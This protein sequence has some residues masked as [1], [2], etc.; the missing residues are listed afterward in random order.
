MHEAQLHEENAFITLTYAPENLPSGGT[1]NKGDFQRFM[2][3][4]RKH[5][6]G[7]KLGFYHC[8]EYGDE[9]RRPHYHAIL[10]GVRFLDQQPYTRATDG[11]VLYT[12]A[13]LSRLWPSGFATV[14]EVTF[15]SAAYVARYVMKKISGPAARDHYTVVDRE[16][17]ELTQLLPE[18]T[19]MSL[20]PAIAKDWYGKYS[21]D[22][23]PS[24]EV[25]ICGKPMKPPQYYDRI[26]EKTNLELHTAIKEQRKQEAQ[27][28]SAHST[29]R[30]LLEREE[31]K[32]AQTRNLKR[33]LS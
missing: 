32:H 10:F 6:S 25:V 22:V 15:E 19:T 26:L 29:T 23:Y 24:D 31:I 18:Y 28:H 17:G 13:L 33:K 14:G 27:K 11:T 2:K 20:K 21:S 9:G 8:G 4:L 30:R 3:R 1:L 5:F 7:R 12:S 16:T